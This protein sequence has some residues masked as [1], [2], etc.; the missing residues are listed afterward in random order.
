MAF[1][2]TVPES[3]VGDK[4]KYLSA[5]GKTE[6]VAFVQ[7]VT[8]VP[9]STHWN[10]G[11]KVIDARVGAIPKYTAIATFDELGKYP[12]DHRGMHAAIYVSH[13]PQKKIIYVLDQFNSQ[14]RV[15]PR[16]IR[17]KENKDGPDYKRSN[18]SDTF[19]V[20]E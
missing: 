20:I 2:M 8:S 5:K 1:V 16:P 3:S 12:T 15:L 7:G 9:K 11:V 14:H 18:D 17:F 19:Y 13:D 10:R 6:C 4:D